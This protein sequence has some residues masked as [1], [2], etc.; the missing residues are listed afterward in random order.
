M[1]FIGT[2]LQYLWVNSPESAVCHV[3][4]IDYGQQCLC[5]R[6]PKS[7]TISDYYS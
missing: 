4:G 2:K 6:H 3:T 5:L 1:V 7:S